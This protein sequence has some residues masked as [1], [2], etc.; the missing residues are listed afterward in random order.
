MKR[1]IFAL[2][3]S[4]AMLLTMSASAETIFG[5]EQTEKFRV[6]GN[7]AVTG[8]PENDEENLC[9]KTFKERTGVDYTV[10]AYNGD[11]YITK[12]QLYVAS[13]NMPDMWYGSVDQVM[14]WK[15]QGLI[16]PLTD[17]I[18]EYGK[19]MLPYIYESSLEAFT[20][21][22]EIYGLPSM[23]LLSEPGNDAASTSMILRKDWLENLELEAPG[24]I[25][26]LHDVLYAFTY[27][28]PDGDGEN[29]TFGLA[30]HSSILSSG[31]GNGFNL[32]Y[33]AYGIT[34]QHWFMRDGEA[35][36]GFMT[37]EFI[38]AVG[39]LRE[40]YAE[41]IIDPEFV[42]MSGDNIVEKMVNGKC[43]AFFNSAWDIQDDGPKSTSAKALNPE[44]DIEMYPSLEGVYGVGG[45]PAV[46]G[47]WRTIVFSSQC[48][49]PELLMS[50]LNWFALD[51]ENWLLSEN[52]IRG[53]HWDFDE[54]GKIDRISPYDTFQTLYSEG[55]CNVSRLQCMTDRRYNTPD[56]LA[57]IDTANSSQLTNAFWGSVPAMN[58]YPD[59]ESNV[60]AV[61]T[62]VIQGTLEMDAL[63]DMQAEYLAQGGQEI[64]DQ[65]NE[66]LQ[67][68]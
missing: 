31:G 5:I 20:F 51:V 4:L 14:E 66:V 15:N 36:K 3:L 67:S 50:F 60:E 55:F 22:G 23:Y 54:N 49:Q 25:E 46:F 30:S 24:T 19:D 11:D 27:N 32:V 47:S 34:P 42:V 29:N 40:W 16:M 28:D 18:N 21:D 7:I 48:K 37:D 39:V 64:Q 17:L 8:Y 65:V 59:L 57:A 52:G 12:L 10:E 56:V 1:R 13:G 53:V 9:I 33:N 41:G 45:T 61:V 68:K 26:E 6:L 63:K 58:E 43:G 62:K 2:A 35:V 44:F 38:E